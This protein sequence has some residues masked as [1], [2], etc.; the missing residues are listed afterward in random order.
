MGDVGQSVGGNTAESGSAGDFIEEATPH[1]AEFGQEDDDR[2]TIVTRREKRPRKLNQ[3]SGFAGAGLRFKKKRLTGSQLAA[4]V[5]MAE[6]HR[7][8]FGVFSKVR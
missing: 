5:G 1:L 3:R 8:V 7:S 2:D 4:G 6:W